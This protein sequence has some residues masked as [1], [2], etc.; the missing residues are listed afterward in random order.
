MESD[1]KSNIISTISAQS[2]VAQ[3]EIKTWAIWKVQE[4]GQPICPGGAPLSLQT[5]MGS[6][7]AAASFATS[8][9]VELSHRSGIT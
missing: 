3:L 5:V 6:I 9:M 7:V 4:K 2:S 1:W 8:V